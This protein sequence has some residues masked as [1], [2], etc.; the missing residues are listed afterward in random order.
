MAK[1]SPRGRSIL[2]L[3]FERREVFQIGN[4]K[5]AYGE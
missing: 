4:E 1:K 3:C 5:S 2:N